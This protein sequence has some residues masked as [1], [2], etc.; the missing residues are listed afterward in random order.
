MTMLD[1]R[2]VSDV[3]DHEDD[4][5]GIRPSD[6]RAKKVGWLE[7]TVSEAGTCTKPKKPKPVSVKKLRSG[8]ASLISP[9]CLRKKQIKDSN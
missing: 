7:R 1:P 3:Y 2:A 6:V 5:R 9:K 4:E 8:Q